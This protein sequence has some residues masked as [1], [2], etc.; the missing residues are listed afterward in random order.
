[1]S[2]GAA[3]VLLTTRRKAQELKLPILGRFR[4]YA[5]VGVEPS[6]MGI[7]ELSSLQSACSLQLAACVAV[8]SAN[9]NDTLLV[10]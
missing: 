6:V 4:A 10:F 1:M 8:G 3:A 5:A 7:G 2:D 9:A